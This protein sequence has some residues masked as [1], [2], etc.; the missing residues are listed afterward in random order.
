MLDDYKLKEALQSRSQEVTVN[1]HLKNK[2]RHYVDQKQRK[3]R[4]NY[5]LSLAIL[6]CLMIGIVCVDTSHKNSAQD[7]QMRIATTTNTPATEIS[8]PI[9][10]IDEDTLAEFINVVTK[11][12]HDY[13]VNLCTE[14][15]NLK[16][17]ELE[18]GKISHYFIT[19]VN[20]KPDLDDDEYINKILTSLNYEL[21]QNGVYEKAALDEYNYIIYKRQN[22]RILKYYQLFMN[23]QNEVTNEQS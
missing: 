9:G 18:I 10:S 17:Y 15:H 12:I 5:H 6:S 14:H 7:L 22:E 20:L 11:D 1:E 19:L 4:S 3:V 23:Q 2:T 8:E 16:V 21:E 13:K